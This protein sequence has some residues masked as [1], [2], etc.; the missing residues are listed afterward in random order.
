MQVKEQ[1]KLQDDLKTKINVEIKEHYHLDLT[2]LLQLYIFL[3]KRN[4]FQSYDQK[5]IINTQQI[6]QE[7]LKL[8]K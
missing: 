6:K 7:M 4:L 8:L 1:Y 5:L 2:M 3:I